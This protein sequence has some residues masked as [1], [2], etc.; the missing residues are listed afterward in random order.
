[1]GKKKKNS[2][3]NNRPCERKDNKD[4]LVFFVRLLNGSKIE[5]PSKFIEVALGHFAR[6]KHLREIKIENVNF[7]GDNVFR[8]ETFREHFRSKIFTYL[9]TVSGLLFL[10]RNNNFF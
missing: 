5:K 9:Q 3:S 7:V 8:I 4:Q 2:A 10:P 1:M 6:M